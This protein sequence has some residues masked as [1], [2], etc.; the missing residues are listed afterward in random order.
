MQCIVWEGAS[1]AAFLLHEAFWETRERKGQEFR[2]L[3][4]SEEVT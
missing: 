2:L 1:E 3:W 4:S